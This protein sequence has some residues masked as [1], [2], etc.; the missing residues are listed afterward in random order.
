MKKP[1]IAVILLIAIGTVIFFW[2]YRKKPQDENIIRVSGNI[3]ITDTAVSFKLPGRVESRLVSEGD[4]VKEGQIVATQ[5]KSDLQKEVDVQRAQVDVATAN[6]KEL[7]AGSRPDEIQQ[8]EAVLARAKAEQERWQKDYQRQKGLFDKGV[9]SERE[10]EATRMSLETATAR[11]RETSEALTLLRKG[12]R[13][14]KIE[15]ARAQLHQAREALALAET[16]LGYTTLASPLTGLVLSHN[17][18][19]GEYVSAGTAVI[20]VG[21]MDAVWL[22]AYVDETDL[23]RVRVGQMVQVRTD[24]FPGKTYEGR[25]S[26]IS[27]ESEFTPKTVQTEKERVKLV[28]RIKIDIPNPQSELKAGMPADGEIRISG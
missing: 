12:P 28:Y 27:S 20:T 1:L 9:I 25:I 2:I 8:Q 23:G 3:E 19:A 22:R 24:S 16:K 21:K 13:I 5:D 11:V 10:L 6:L 14:E 15:Q 17:I 18:E 4:S 26:F 7:E